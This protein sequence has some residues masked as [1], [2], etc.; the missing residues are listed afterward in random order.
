MDIETIE[1]MA[2]IIETTEIIKAT[3]DLILIEILI[4]NR[5]QIEIIGAIG[6]KHAT[7]C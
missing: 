6:A 1:I 2:T 3:E 7:F 5:I 4:F